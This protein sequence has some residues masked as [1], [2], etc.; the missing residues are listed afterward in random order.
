MLL[1]S[2][3]K[4]FLD[5]YDGSELQNLFFYHLNFTNKLNFCLLVKYLPLVSQ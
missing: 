5:L 1:V 2:N 3:K 4:T